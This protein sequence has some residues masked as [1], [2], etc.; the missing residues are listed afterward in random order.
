MALINLGGN[1]RV[2]DFGGWL[3]AWVALIEL[4][5]NCGA[6]GLGGWLRVWVALIKLEGNWGVP[7]FS[8]LKYP[9]LRRFC[10]FRELWGGLLWFTI[11][12]FPGGLG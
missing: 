11:A 9:G 5:G 12:G 3:R 7:G 8:V 1:C 4:E 10:R 6:P 2:P